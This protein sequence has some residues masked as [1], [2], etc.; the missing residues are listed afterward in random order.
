MR[1]VKEALHVT[2]NREP[3][4]HQQGHPRCRVGA[5]AGGT[6]APCAEPGEVDV[7]GL[8]LC[9]AHALEARLEGQIDCWDEVLFHV[10][11]WSREAVR[12][13]RAGVVRL[14]EVRREEASSARDRACADLERAKGEMP[15]GPA[16]RRRAPTRGPPILPREGGRPPSRGHR[17]RRRR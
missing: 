3:C 1:V 12:R 10:D 16:G 9:K 8:L 7:D 17:R 14:L 11:L 15:R 6:P 4:V 2:G 13:D 5:R